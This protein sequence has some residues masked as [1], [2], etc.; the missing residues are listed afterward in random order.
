MSGGIACLVP[1]LDCAV[2]QW[3]AGSGLALPQACAK[4][5]WACKLAGKLPVASRRALQNELNEEGCRAHWS[6]LPEIFKS[7]SP[8]SAA[9][10][11]GVAVAT[12]AAADLHAL[13]VQQQQQQRGGTHD[14]GSSD[15]A[16]IT[17][18]EQ[19]AALPR[20]QHGSSEEEPEQ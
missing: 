9:T 5:V 19:A 7:D 17:P 14:A 15:G 16:P 4:L 2:G 3:M 11:R 13:E 12:T 1:T 10:S 8:A 18:T 6:C 20:Q